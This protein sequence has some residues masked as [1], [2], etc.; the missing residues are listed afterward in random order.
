VEQLSARSQPKGVE[1]GTE[2]LFE[3][4]WTH[5]WRVAARRVDAPRA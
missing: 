2:P 4:I 1:V 3:V 5:G